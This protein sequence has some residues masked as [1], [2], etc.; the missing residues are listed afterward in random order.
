MEGLESAGLEEWSNAATKSRKA[1]C[2]QEPEETTESQ[3][4]VRGGGQSGQHLDSG[5]GTLI[6]ESWLPEV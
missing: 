1:G 5:P 6:L 2:H 3:G 4:G